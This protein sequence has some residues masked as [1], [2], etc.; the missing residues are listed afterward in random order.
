MYITE[1]DLRDLSEEEDHYA[2]ASKLHVCLNAM[3]ADNDDY[4][5]DLDFLQFAVRLKIQASQAK[6]SISA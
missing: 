6:T 3:D 5:S 1:L 2:V 4:I